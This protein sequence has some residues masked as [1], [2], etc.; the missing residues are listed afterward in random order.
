MFLALQLKSSNG[1]KLPAHI[2]FTGAQ[3]LRVLE[4]VPIH[5]GGI[6]RAGHDQLTFLPAPEVIIVA[7]ASDRDRDGAT[8]VHGCGTDNH[9]LHPL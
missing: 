1:S 2:R 5:D 9:E 7:G 4:A 6:M 3:T 8:Y